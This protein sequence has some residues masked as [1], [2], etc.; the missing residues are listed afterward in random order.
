MEIQIIIVER[1][2]LCRC[3]KK[4]AD[5]SQIIIH[6]GDKLREIATQTITE[7]LQISDAVDAILMN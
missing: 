7:G 4:G 2:I 5:I 6:R 3:R 1:E